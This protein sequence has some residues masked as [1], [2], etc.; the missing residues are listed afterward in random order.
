MLKEKNLFHAVL[1]RESLEAI[2]HRVELMPDSVS[3]LNTLGQTPL[4]LAIEIKRYDVVRFLIQA[5]TPYA[6]DILYKGKCLIH[7]AAE[8]GNIDTVRFI[9][10]RYPGSVNQLDSVGETALIYAARK[11][12]QKIVDY[13]LNCEGVDVHCKAKSP[14]TKDAD[15]DKDWN[16]LDWA[17]F[18]KHYVI[19]KRLVQAGVTLSNARDLILDAAIAGDLKRVRFMVETYPN[20]V[21]EADL[22]GRTVLIRATRWGH[23]EIVRY[24]MQNG[25]DPDCIDN[26]PG[27]KNNGWRAVDWARK[28]KHQA[29]V[30]LLTNSAPKPVIRENMSRLLLAP[31][32]AKRVSEE[33][34]KV[35][36]FDCFDDWPLTSV[37]KK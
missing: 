17:V 24:L 31:P 35:D 9:V 23:L 11:G 37:L 5:N 34:K 28:N 13:L 16:A 1:E 26:D 7:Q 25:A 20:S 12:D 2:Q 8:D 36:E 10:G 3:H 6:P 4:D 33:E 30:D 22:Y 19:A 32:V 29:I 27:E 18:K 14:E 15:E 21:N